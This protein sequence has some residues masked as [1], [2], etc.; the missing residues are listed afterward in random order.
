MVDSLTRMK[1]NLLF[2]IGGDGTLRGAD[3]VAA[4]LARHFKTTGREVFMKYLDPSYRIPSVAAI[5]TDAIF[6]YLLAEER[7]ARDAREK[8]DRS[9][10]AL[11][12]GILSATRQNDYF[13]I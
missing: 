3:A 1:V 11:W 8:T 13:G 10:G 7:R 12:K 6:C 4:E 5:S 2:C 9:G